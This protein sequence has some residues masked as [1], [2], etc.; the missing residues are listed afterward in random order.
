VQA[1]VANGHHLLGTRLQQQQ[2]QQQDNT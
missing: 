1:G 2:Q